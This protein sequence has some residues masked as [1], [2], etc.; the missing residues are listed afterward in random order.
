MEGYVIGLIIGSGVLLFAVV[1]VLCF[2]S[3]F[4]YRTRSE[5]YKAYKEGRGSRKVVRASSPFDADDT[6]PEEA[7]DLAQR[8]D[9]MIRI[10]GRSEVWGISRSRIAEISQIPESRVDALFNGEIEKFTVD[11]LK[12]I[13]LNLKA[14]VIMEG[15]KSW[16]STQ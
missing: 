8:A 5:S 12:A 15:E 6:R 9:L 11:Q 4:V 2:A 7:I 10:R 14:H 3:V 1:F 16:S 13:D